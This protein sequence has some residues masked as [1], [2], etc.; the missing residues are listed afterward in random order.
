M[1]TVFCTSCGGK[2]EYAGFAPNFCSKCGNPMSGKA[3]KAQPPQKMSKQSVDDY[4][5][6]SEDNSDI[7]EV[8]DIEKL[9]V[10]IEMEG[11]FRTF[12]LED[13][14]RNPQTA[15]SRKFSSRR[16]GGIDGLSPTK[17][18]STKERQD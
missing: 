1:A 14:S 12:S 13:L 6:E 16:V 4:E 9:D 5:D 2:H 10:E 7:D 3:A 15:Q 17:Y 8:P 18:G 11:G